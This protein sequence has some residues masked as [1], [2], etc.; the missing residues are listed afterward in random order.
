LSGTVDSH[1]TAEPTFTIAGQLRLRV[2]A[3]DTLV[4]GT[5]DGD[6]DA[7]FAIR[8]LGRTDLKDTDF[9]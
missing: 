4:E 6:A 5:T 3:G 9:S 7:E 2:D 1:L 8:I